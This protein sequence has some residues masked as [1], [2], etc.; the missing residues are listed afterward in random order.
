MVRVVG[1]RLSS[2]A[3]DRP[4][5]PEES[6]II[7]FAQFWKVYGTCSLA[8][9]ASGTDRSGAGSLLCAGKREPT[10]QYS[11]IKFIPITG[12]EAPTS[13]KKLELH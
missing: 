9:I 5:L 3:C 4:S 1:E 12:K 7:G 13:G 10:A 11:M 8:A 2:C 6:Y